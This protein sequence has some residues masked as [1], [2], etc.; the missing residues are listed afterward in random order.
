MDSLPNACPKPF[1]GQATLER[2]KKRVEHRT[3]AD[4]VKA[5]AKTRDGRRCRFP[6]CR[7]QAQGFVLDGAH[8]DAAGMGGNPDE[9]RMTLENILSTCRWH[10][11]GP[12]S[13]HSG[14]LRVEVR[15]PKAGANGMVDWYRTD[16]QKKWRHV[17]GTAP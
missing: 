7:M 11:R 5:Q 1:R 13:L 9:S 16:E 17:G 10:H 3:H 15:D 2:H 4:T 8:I 14:D 6:G 12:C